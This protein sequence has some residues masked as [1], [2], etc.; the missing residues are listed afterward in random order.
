MD[1]RYISRDDQLADLFTKPVTK[2]RPSFLLSK[3]NL[4]ELTELRLRETV[5][6]EHC[7]ELL[8]S[9]ETTKAHETKS[10]SQPNSFYRPSDKHS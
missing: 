7:D 6:E 1:V 4:Y 9:K 8:Q 10:K 5:G 2:I 3:L